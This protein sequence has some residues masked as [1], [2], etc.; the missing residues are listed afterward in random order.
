MI[1]NYY[2][3]NTNENKNSTSY[4]N[5]DPNNINSIVNHSA[6]SI[7]CDCLEYLSKDNLNGYLSL[8]LDKIKPDGT[9]TLMIDDIKQKCQNLLDSKIDPTDLLISIKKYSNILLPENIYTQIDVTKFLIVQIA[10]ENHKILITLKR[11]SL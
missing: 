2:L 6:D 3:T 1:R 5:I 10:K 9:L 8:V 7:F 11:I 4:I